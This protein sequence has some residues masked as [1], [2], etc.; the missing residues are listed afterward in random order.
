MSRSRGLGGCIPW[1]VRSRGNER[2]LM[3][4][5]EGGKRLNS[6]T[7]LYVSSLVVL[8]SESEGRLWNFFFF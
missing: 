7:G 8:T 5:E 1:H 4:A 2:E 3:G 6:E